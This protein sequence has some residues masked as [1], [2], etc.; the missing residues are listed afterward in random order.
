MADRLP[1]FKEIVDLD[2]NKM[3]FSPILYATTSDEP[4][5]E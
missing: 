5:D 2:N 3:G 4:K 1:Y